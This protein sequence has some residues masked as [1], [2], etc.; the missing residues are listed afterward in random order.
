M[1]KKRCLCIC[2]ISSATD[3]LMLGVEAKVESCWQGNATANVLA[4]PGKYPFYLLLLHVTVSRAASRIG[5][6]KN[7]RKRH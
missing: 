6:R 1:V 5:P 7:P 3:S 4:L 2:S